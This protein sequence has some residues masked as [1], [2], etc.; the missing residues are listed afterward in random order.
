MRDKFSLRSPLRIFGTIADFLFLTCYMRLFHL[1]R[2]RAIQATA[3]SED[4]QEFLGTDQQ[5]GGP[6]GP[7]REAESPRQW[8]TGSIFVL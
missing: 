5:I 3:E 7:N 6:L 1:E 4:W 2:N 8:D